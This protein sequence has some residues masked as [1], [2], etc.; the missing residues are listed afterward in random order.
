ME[1]I[2][3][4]Q[5]EHKFFIWQTAWIS[6]ET[7]HCQKLDFLLNIFAADSMGLSLLVFM[8]LFLKVAVSDAR[9]T[10]AKRNLTR[11]SH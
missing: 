10:G 11:N 5:F 7:L 8:Q 6:A 2:K 9:H 4:A 3:K 1:M